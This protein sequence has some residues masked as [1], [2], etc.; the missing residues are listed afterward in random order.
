MRDV[1]HAVG[2][3][4]TVLGLLLSLA[5]PTLPSLVVLAVGAGLALVTHQPGV[6]GPEVD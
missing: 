1:L 4:L 5:Y 6:H 3:G 2:L